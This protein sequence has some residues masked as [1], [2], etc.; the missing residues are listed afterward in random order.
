MKHN[1][2]FDRVDIVDGVTSDYR[3]AAVSVIISEQSLEDYNGQVMSVVAA[4][5][6][7]RW[8]S[9]I[10]FSIPRDARCLLPG[11]P[12]SFFDYLEKTVA[13]SGLNCKFTINSQVDETDLR[14]HVGPT[15]ENNMIWISASG[16]VAGCGFN[17]KCDGGSQSA[18]SGF[19]ASFAACLGVAEL[20]RRALGQP[21]TPFKV[22]YSL[23]NYEQGID[24]SALQNPAILGGCDFGILHIIGSG[25]IG[26]CFAYLLTLAHDIK[27]SAHLIDHDEIDAPNIPAS[28]V[29]SLSQVGGNVKKVDACARLS[30]SNIELLPFPDDYEAFIKSGRHRTSPA[31]VILCF[32]NERNI[33][34]TI[35]H[36]CPPVVLHATTS[37]NWGTNFGRHIPEK[38]WCILC[39]FGSQLVSTVPLDC[40]K[41]ELPSRTEQKRYGVLPFLA[42]ASA[43]IAFAELYKMYM[44]ENHQDHSNFVEFSMKNSVTSFDGWNRPSKSCDVCREQNPKIYPSFVKSSKLWQLIN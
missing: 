39:R 18:P 24:R 7:G 27:G 23:Y 22:W 5:I 30:N 37:P 19:A 34:S 29:F 8:A 3:V 43:S 40:A 41:G 28:L 33:W 32:A 21:R 31:D 4:N 36:N 44:L 12:E 1:N 20:F 6:L 17:E 13:Q 2:I 25:A 14:L 16:W 35:Q 26:S 42:A 11:A 38:D 10:N 15:D 9:S